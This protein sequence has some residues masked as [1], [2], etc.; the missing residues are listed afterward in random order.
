MWLLNNGIIKVI[1][2]D[3]REAI[4]S[5]LGMFTPK[6]IVEQMM[7]E[8]SEDP[9][10]AILMKLTFLRLKDQE[11]VPQLASDAE[12][13]LTPGPPGNAVFVPPPTIGDPSVP[14][15]AQPVGE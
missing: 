3:V 8:G 14:T 5:F 7:I 6:T 15:N 4:R 11:A 2:K 9:M 13:D 10:T 12:K 1:N